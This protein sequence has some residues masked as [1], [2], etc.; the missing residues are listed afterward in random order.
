MTQGKEEAKRPNNPDYTMS[1]VSIKN[2][3]EVK[4][5]LD[6]W[7]AAKKLSDKASE[8]LDFARASV[9]EL[10][11]EVKVK[12]A[13]KLLAEARSN[14]EV[15]V[16]EFGGY[17]DTE[18]GLYAL[19]QVRKTITYDPDKVKANIPTY[20]DK[21]LAQVDVNVLKGLLRGKLIT[22]EQVDN[23]AIA[24]ESLMFVIQAES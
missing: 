21:I 15:A 4:V 6:E 22:Q 23:C 20:A 12:E 13:G 7:M 1:A 5:L 3:P 19:Q 8:N 9:P 2:P 24:K 10:P 16:K 17:Q 11:E 18:A 14:L